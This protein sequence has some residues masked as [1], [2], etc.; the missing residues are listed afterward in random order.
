MTEV[1]AAQAGV[2][3]DVPTGTIHDVAAE[4]GCDHR[5]FPRR[6]GRVLAR[7][8]SDAVV[9]ELGERG[10][11][12][13]TFEGVAARAGTGKSTLYRRW[14]DKPSMVVDC[15]ADALP[16]LDNHELA[17]DLREDLLT[18]MQSYAVGCSGPLGVALRAICGTAGGCDQLKR[19]WKER[20]ADPAIE[21]MRGIVGGAIE[22][23]EARPGADAYECLIAGPAIIGQLYM[24]NDTAPTLDEVTRLVDNV[25]VPMMAVR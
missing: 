6:R 17:G 19:L 7:A 21:R 3:V 2:R 4:V 15:L 20:A 13:L 1:Q 25:L 24:A 9:A 8:I 23:G 16:V 11:S 22:R 5:R 10:Y 18:V 12:A 14:A